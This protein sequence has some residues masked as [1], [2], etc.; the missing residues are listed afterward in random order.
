MPSAWAFSID[1]RTSA[2]RLSTAAASLGMMRGRRRR[3]RNEIAILD[4]QQPFAQRGQRA[5]TFAV[6]AFGGDIADQQAERAGD[7]RREDLLVELGE[8]EERGQ[9]KEE[10]SNAGRARQDRVADLLGRACSHRA[11]CAS[12]GGK[13]PPR[14]RVNESRLRKSQRAALASQ[15]EIEAAAAA[16]AAMRTA[17]RCNIARRGAM[18][19]ASHGPPR[20]SCPRWTGGSPG[21]WWPVIS[22]STRSPRAIA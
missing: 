12:R 20:G 18:P 16:V 9:R 13:S 4:R 8:V 1:A 17:H 7:D 15:N 6:G 2:N 14:T 21:R 19:R 22:S 10:G 3:R 5:G 11:W